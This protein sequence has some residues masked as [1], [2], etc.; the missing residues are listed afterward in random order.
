M[1]DFLGTIATVALT[2]FI[3]SSLLAVLDVSRETKVV[4][5]A[6]LGLWVGIAT[7]ASSAGWAA[8]A[9][10][11]PIMGLFVAAPLT[12]AIVATA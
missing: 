9:R 12:V 2:I 4:M 11:F 1:L 5:A 3:I 10:P 8:I 6:L 7:A